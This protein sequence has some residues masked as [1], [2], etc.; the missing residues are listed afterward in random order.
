MKA[1]WGDTD[2]R[3]VESSKYYL[4]SWKLPKQFSA[5]QKPTKY[6]YNFKASCGI[7]TGINPLALE[8]DI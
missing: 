6:N 1:R 4:W 2:K 3:E 8:M 5:K 7:A